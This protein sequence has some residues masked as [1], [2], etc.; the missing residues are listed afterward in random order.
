MASSHLDNLVKINQLKREPGSQQELDG[1]IRS[2]QNRLRDAKIPGM[3]FD[4]RFDLNY[5]AS[6]ALALAALRWYGYRSENRYIVFQ[7]LEHTLGLP[8]KEWRVLA[9]C[10]Q[11]RN[12]AEYEG[13]LEADEQL[14]ADLARIANDLLGLVLALKKLA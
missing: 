10:H 1:L 9:T 11:R 7:C 8:A 5:N 14:V 4:G 3:T 2:A 13:N 6:H 12:A